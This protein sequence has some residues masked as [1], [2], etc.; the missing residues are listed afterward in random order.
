MIKHPFCGFRGFPLSSEFRQRVKNS[1]VQFK[2]STFSQ[3]CPNYLKF[4][5]F[6][7]NHEV[8]DLYRCTNW[9]NDMHAVLIA[10][11]LV[12]IKDEVDKT[13]QTFRVALVF[14]QSL[15]IDIFESL[16]QKMSANISSRVPQLTL[17]LW[18]SQVE[19]CDSA[20]LS[21]R[22]QKTPKN[23]AVALFFF[24]LCELK[25]LNCWMTV[26]ALNI[27]LLAYHAAT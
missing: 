24:N 10:V 7:K 23:S 4:E 9:A 16:Y 22:R 21:W 27:L 2:N 20:N 12:L 5:N 25:D 18:L 6:F 1:I 8:H 17:L 26:V 19:A 3:V 13:T 11:K 15:R 14:F